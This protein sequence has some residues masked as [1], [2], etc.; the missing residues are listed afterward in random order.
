ME[1]QA[2]NLVWECIHD[3]DNTFRKDDIHNV[4]HEELEEL[5]IR[6]DDRLHVAVDDVPWWERDEIAEREF[7]VQLA[8]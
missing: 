3:I 6:I 8:Q 1:T 7:M 5:I 2:E 4:S